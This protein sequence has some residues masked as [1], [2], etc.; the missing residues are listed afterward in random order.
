M[1]TTL[2]TSRWALGVTAALLGL[3]AGCGGSS[4]TSTAAGSGGGGGGALR[5]TSPAPG[6]DVT[7]PFML[8]WSSKAALGPPDS[9]K[10][11][12]HVF[13]DGKSNDYTVVG[14]NQFQIKGLS[15][16]KHTLQ[17]TLQHADH[18]PVGPS[19]SVSVTVAGAGAGGSSS[20]GGGPR[21]Y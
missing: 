19:S 1:R 18:T 13:V 20:T 12:V 8:T 2:Q 4:T 6:A 14:G 5:I 21:G 9:G 16:G 10:D 17:V 15:A 7:E 3:L 11:H